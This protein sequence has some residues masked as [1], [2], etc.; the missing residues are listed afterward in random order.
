MPASS[1]E[2]LHHLHAVK[3]GDRIVGPVI[4]PFLQRYG[5]GLTQQ[6]DNARPHTA[7]V[8]QRYMEQH[9]VDLRGI[10]IK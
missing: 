1:K 6:Q 2:S 10:V 9:D 8:I 5:P 7:R 4:I 3:Y